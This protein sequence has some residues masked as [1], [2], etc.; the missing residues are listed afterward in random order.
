M[1]LLESQATE[2]NYL[3]ESPIPLMNDQRQ[4]SESGSTP[5]ASGKAPSKRKA[6]EDA[7]PNGDAPHTRAKRNR[8]ISIAWYVEGSFHPAG[9]IY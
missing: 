7:N 2:I 9:A 3:A 6:G 8:Y 1:D 5:K 4:I